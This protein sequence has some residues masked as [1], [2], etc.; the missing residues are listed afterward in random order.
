MRLI[1]CTSIAFSNKLANLVQVHSM[2]KEFQRQ[3]GED[4]YLGVN[5]KNTDDK[6][7]NIICFNS[8]KSYILA[9]KY[10]KFIKREKI[11]YIYCR[12]SILLLCIIVFNKLFFRQKIK[13]AYEIHALPL[14]GWHSL[15]AEN[16]LSKAV[17]NFIFVT[18]NLRN[19]YIK[20]FRCASKNMLVF[21][22][23]V[24]LSIFNI[25]MDKETARK[26]LNLPQNKRII[27]YTG[28]FKTMDMDKGIIDILKA[29][30]IL[31]NDIIFL[32]IGGS[33]KDII[34]YEGKAKEENVFDRVKFFGNVN[35]KTLAIY[36]KASDLLLM[37]FPFT[38]H[39][40]YYMSPLKMFEYMASQ[41]PIIASDLPSV[42]EILNENNSLLA[43]PGDSKD[44]ARGI[45]EILNNKELSDK[46]SKQAFFDVKQ[47]TWERRVKKIL[48]FIK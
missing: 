22:D 33:K 19:S 1:Y 31:D 11:E 39:F 36:Q 4:F 28:R 16:F 29:L 20:K 23:A 40:A 48:D 25:G 37:P 2:A 35:Q 3:L 15:I 34:E 41:R 6:S 30:K 26:E 8:R 27:L 12:E 14:G 17:K 10:L 9:W 32:A 5:Y 45:E 7:I 13:V 44:L 46:I 24:D 21:P 42:R 38:Q 18:E 43:K 47:Y